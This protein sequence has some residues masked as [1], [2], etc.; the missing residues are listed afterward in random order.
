MLDASSAAATWA[1]V[2][3]VEVEVKNVNRTFFSFGGGVQSTAIALR[4]IHE[5]KAFG[6]LG[7]PRLII[8]ADTG[9][10]TSQ[11]YQ[12]VEQMFELLA[13][14]GYD[15]AV[16][17]AKRKDGNSSSILD[18]PEGARMG[19][20]TPPY[21]TRNAD[22]SK[23]L[24]LR[25]CTQEYKI[26]PIQKRIRVELGY[27]PR[28]VVPRRSVNLWLGISIDEAHRM[29]DNRDKWLINTY[30]LIEWNW[31]RARCAVYCQEKLNY[32]VPKSACYFCPFTHH[33][34]W[35]R[36]KQLEPENFQLA[37][38]FDER[39]RNISNCGIKQPCYIHPSCYPLAQV[40]NDQLLLALGSD[41]GFA[42]ECEG[43]CGV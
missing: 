9:A 5:P 24:L 34:E 37:V 27:V 17:T 43:H 41:H 3:L 14:A 10:E 32:P 31:D 11:T 21:F 26:T 30:P 40:V 20:S 4:L 23:G 2:V 38:D 12:H 39:I 36:R 1:A 28:Q 29:K 35:V 33:S 42:N 6:E 15:T 25:Q 13:A 22:G 18:D 7:L 16:V 8:F 19:I